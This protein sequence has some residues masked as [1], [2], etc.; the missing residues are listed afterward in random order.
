[1]DEQMR[2]LL[3]SLPKVDVLLQSEGLEN[4]LDQS[5][6]SVVKDAVQ[7]VLQ[8]VRQSIR[9]GQI[10]TA[11]TTE[12][13]IS[14]VLHQ[15]DTG[16]P[17]H[18][19][20]LINGTGTVL[21]TNL[22]R[23]VMSKDIARHVAAIAS[24]YSNLE[25]DLNT[26][27]RGTR[28]SHVEDL[29]MKLTGAEA[30]LVVN[31]N[32][33]AVMLALAAMTKGKE[34]VISRGELVEIGGMFR[35]PEVIAMSG[36]IIHE[37][38]TTNK[39]HLNDYRQAVNEQTGAIMK[40]HTSNYRIIGFTESA[41]PVGVAVIAHEQGVP[42]I[43]DLGS[44]LLL[45]MTRFGLPYEP[46]VQESIAHGADIVT[47]SGDK[48]LGG[49]QAG[50]IVG[51]KVYIDAMKKH[52]LLRALR[53]DK[54]TLAALEATLQLYENE[55]VAVEQI[56]VLQ[57]LA[58]TQEQCQKRAIALAEVL[59]EKLPDFVIGTAPCEDM[60]GGGSYPEYALSGYAVTVTMNGVNAEEVKAKLHH[61]NPAVI[62]RVQNDQL[63]L[64]LRTIAPIDYETIA[65]A[66]RQLQC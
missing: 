53:V 48:L 16:K 17:S 52:Q 25:Y 40:V 50:I 55:E 65:N 35:I 12:T 39:T 9:R 5:P 57:M 15:L 62:G 6:R 24:S 43:H 30:A 41:D 13:I 34:V 1:M 29:L 26:G 47:F 59:Q 14:L 3:A 4:A 8:Q 51:K 38:G 56:P 7:Y 44:G 11:P 49:P 42:F 20:T 58:I 45:N 66:L 36:A 23:S 10:Q 32:A 37:V 54:M 18:L 60:V 61:T 27:S 21:H 2:Q 33:A 64:S 19:R 28:Y 31:N 63:Y 22:G 46:T